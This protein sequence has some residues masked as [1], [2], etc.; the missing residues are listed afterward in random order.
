MD[1][2]K[3]DRKHI[4]QHKLL[5]QRTTQ[6]KIQMTNDDNNHHIIQTIKMMMLYMKM[7]VKHQVENFGFVTFLLTTQVRQIHLQ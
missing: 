1:D 5:H 2:D 4:V 3:N 7:L 6:H